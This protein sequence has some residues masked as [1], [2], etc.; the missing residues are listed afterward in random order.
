MN[1]LATSSAAVL[2]QSGLITCDVLAVKSRLTT[3]LIP[4]WEITT[5]VIMKTYQLSAEILVRYTSPFPLKS[6][7]IHVHVH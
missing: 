7:S 3:V 6:R 1:S 4:A 5:A 2:V